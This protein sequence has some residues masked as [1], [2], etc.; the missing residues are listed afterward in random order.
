[1]KVRGNHEE[2]L[3]QYL[4]GAKVVTIE[5]PNIRL[6]HELQN[7]VRFC[8]ALL[9][10]GAVKQIKLM[11]RYDDNT[12]LMALRARW[13]NSSKDCWKWMWNCT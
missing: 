10:A 4:P 9:R 11:T 5:D 13:R 1:M 2:S 3:G 8:E 6:L 12:C 7:F